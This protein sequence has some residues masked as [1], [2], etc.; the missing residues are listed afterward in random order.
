MLDRTLP[1]L[2]EVRQE[3]EFH[4]LVGRLTLILLSIFNKSQASSPFDALNSM[5]ISRCQIDVIP[6]VQMRWSL[7]AFSRDSTADSD[8]PSSCEMNDEPELKPLQG[9]PAFF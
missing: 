9:I 2:L 6:P 5:C 3:I 4:F 7:M 1:M 8:N